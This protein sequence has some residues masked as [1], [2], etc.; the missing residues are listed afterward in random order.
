MTSPSDEMAEFELVIERVF[1]D[2]V[3]AVRRTRTEQAQW[4][5]DCYKPRDQERKV[6]VDRFLNAPAASICRVTGQIGAGKTCFVLDKLENPDGRVCSGIWIDIGQ[7]ATRLEA[8]R[9]NAVCEF[10]ELK[11]HEAATESE[12]DVWIDQRVAAVLNE[13]IAEEVK[14]RFSMHFWQ[15]R[16]DLAP[17]YFGVDLEHRVETDCPAP[18]PNDL[19]RFASDVRRRV[20]AAL[21]LVRLDDEA[22]DIREKLFSDGKVPDSRFDQHHQI[23]AHLER[24]SDAVKGARKIKEK[25]D[26]NQ[27]IVRWLRAYANFF[28]KEQLILILDNV[29]RV[30]NPDLHATIIDYARHL[31]YELRDDTLQGTPR[32]DGDARRPNVFKVVYTVRDWNV[33]THYPHMAG[34]PV[35]E[36]P[37][38]LGEKGK[39]YLDR[40]AAPTFLPLDRTLLRDIIQARLDAAKR[41]LP[42]QSTSGALLPLFGSVVNRL[43]HPDTETKERLHLQH[44]TNYSIRKALQMG[45]DVAIRL[46]RDLQA[47]DRDIDDYLAADYRV[48]L[49][50]RVIDWVFGD[51]EHSGDLVGF[52]REARQLVE[53]PNHDEYLCC[54]HRL[55][56]TYLRRLDQEGGQT[57]RT[58]VGVLI[59]HLEQHTNTPPDHTRKVLHFLFQPGDIQ[60]AYIT[61]YQNSPI[62]DAQDI[63]DEASV[64]INPKGR[65]LLTRVMIR[66]EY[67]ARHTH[68]SGPLPHLYELAP[69]EALRLMQPILGT[70]KQMSTAH[71]RN[72]KVLVKKIMRKRGLGDND[73]PLKKFREARLTVGKTFYLERVA[74]S[75]LSAMILYFRSLF[76]ARN[77][78]IL[79]PRRERQ[80]FDQQWPGLPDPPDLSDA[81]D[82]RGLESSVQRYLKL[83]GD[84]ERRSQVS[85][86]YEVTED[87]YEIRTR[88]Y[89]DGQA[90]YSELFPKDA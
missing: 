74:S 80:R 69:D 85:L 43:W 72:W 66:P 44:L 90:T 27:L 67:W 33:R 34:G 9:S 31:T 53:N 82:A 60:A 32:C 78:A 37:I 13:I 28:P 39:G 64:H 47:D 38:T 77:A 79:V 68:M 14:R 6:F 40:Q 46:M 42:E 22:I 5:K 50:S 18:S 12:R 2:S 29:D 16:C 49:R 48:A 3:R 30:F 7:H 35:Q 54:A 41:R 56:L 83:L 62:Y 87:F 51:T 73:R 55:I 76:R 10:A 71:E 63:V 19:I 58:S 15:L 84:E 65:A 36:I 81:G 61:I 89:R 57:G 24:N 17:K 11:A 26:N 4:W 86:L 1:S 25:L 23:V 20:A 21:V 52:I 59:D 8:A 88:L 75:H 45:S 70:I